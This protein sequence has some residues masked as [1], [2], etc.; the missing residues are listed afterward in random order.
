MLTEKYGVGI[1]DQEA[2]N[3]E[4]VEWHNKMVDVIYSII[5]LVVSLGLL[6]VLLVFILTVATGAK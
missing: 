4:R 6:I 2:I 1:Q 5:A 3:K